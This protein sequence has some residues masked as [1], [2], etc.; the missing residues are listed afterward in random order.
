[1]SQIHKLFLSEDYRK[2]LTIAFGVEWNEITD[3]QQTLVTQ[4]VFRLYQI[5][6]FEVEKQIKK[7]ETEPIEFNVVEMNGVGLVKV[8]YVGAWA[9]RICL[10]EGRK[11]AMANKNSETNNMRERLEREMLDL[12][13]NNII[14]FMLLEEE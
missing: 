13:E 11:Y 9:V 3:G 10:N 7:S 6:I 12:L 8:C 14:F 5:L 1:M 2:D 4:L